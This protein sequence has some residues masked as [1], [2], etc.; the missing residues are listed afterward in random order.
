M[1]PH[2]MGALPQGPGDNVIRGANHR[3]WGPVPLGLTAAHDAAEGVS[4]LRQEVEVP[5]HNE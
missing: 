1:T 4:S 2:L 3:R 5:R